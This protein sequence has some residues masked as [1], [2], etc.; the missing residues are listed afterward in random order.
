MLTET[1][2]YLANFPQKIANKL[3]QIEYKKGS[4]VGAGSRLYALASIDNFSGTRSAIT[5]GNYS[6]V[7][8]QLVAFAHGGSINIG[9]YCYIGD[10]SKIWSMSSITI[11]HRVFISHGV[12]IHDNSA[13]SL[14]AKDRHQHFLE[15]F[16]GNGHPAIKTL[17]NVAASP[18]V[19]NDDAWIGFNATVLKGVTIGQGAVVGACSVVTKDVPPYAIVVGNPARIVGAA[20]P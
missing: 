9:D 15:I 14:S 8:G 6:H 13:H 4:V 18:I 7:H 17:L 12:N 11:R 5:I 19:I 16:N 10:H 2:L 20:K 3:R 1:L